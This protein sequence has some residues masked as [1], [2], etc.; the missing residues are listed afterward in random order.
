MMGS[1]T[2]ARRWTVANRRKAK[3]KHQ[4]AEHDAPA[5]FGQSLGHAKPVDRHHKQ[6]FL[7][8][9]IDASA[10]LQALHRVAFQ[11]VL[12]SATVAHKTALNA[13]YPRVHLPKRIAPL[14][15][16]NI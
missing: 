15:G 1:N 7:R 6:R 16:K 14:P 5:R 10:R 9:K 8:P 11:R 3:P 13:T 2:R 12:E 4:V